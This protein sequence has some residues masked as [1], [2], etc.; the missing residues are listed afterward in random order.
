[1]WKKEL[2]HTKRGTFEYFVKG[3]GEPICITHLY[4]QFNEKGY[5][6]ADPFTEH[7]QVFLVN[8]KNAGNSSTVNS[9]EEL[10]MLESVKDLEAI[11]EELGFQRWAFGGHST[12]GM[13][14]L[15]Y[16][17]H[18]PNSLTKVVVGGATASYEYMNHEGSIYSRK[19][20]HNKRLKEIFSLL[21]TSNNRQERRTVAREWLEMSLYRPQ[22]YDIYFSKP[23]SGG[24]VQERLDYYSYEEL[25]NYDIREELKNVKIP[26]IVYCGKH[27][28]QCPLVFSE[29]IH[30]QLQ[31]SFFYCFHES[32]HNP[33]LEEAEAFEE[34]VQAF[35]KLR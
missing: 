12:G 22:N 16:A 20:P 30:K 33:F 24:V 11:R 21:N 13:L 31:H 4:S 6:F 34:M 32:N 23:S 18:F 35:K 29:E 8:L 9:A 10:S 17:I 14:A 1:M 27:D 19:N 7:F 5:Y 3:K 28:S 2:I 15:K 26:A 25:P